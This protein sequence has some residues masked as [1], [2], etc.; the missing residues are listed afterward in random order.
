MTTIQ[1]GP[2]WTKGDVLRK[3]R[4]SAGLSQAELAR[5]LEVDVN[6]VR[7]VEANRS[8]INRSRIYSWAGATGVEVDW[9]D[10]W[11]PRLDS[12]QRPFGYWSSQ[13]SGVEHL[14]LAA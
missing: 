13:V 3:A 5:R 2:A 6:T 14:V 9:F 4:E 1:T 8:P 12:N 7:R 10:Y 11:L